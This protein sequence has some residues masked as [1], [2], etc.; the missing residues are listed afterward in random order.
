[1][2]ELREYLFSIQDIKYKI[3]TQKLVPDTSYEIIGIKVPTLKKIAKIISQNKPFCLTYLEQK[4][5]YFEEVFIHGLVLADHCK[6]ITIAKNLLNNFLPLIDNWS[7]CDCTVSALKCFN[8]EK[9]LGYEFA[10]NLLNSSSPYTIRF[11]IVLLKSYFL[12]ENFRQDS[13]NKLLEIKTDN[14]YIKM[15]IAWFLCEAL[16]KNYQ[17]TI[18]VIINKQFDKFTHNK[19]IQKCL[20]SFRISSEIKTYLKTLKI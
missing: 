14:Y 12:G 16:I 13:I 8:K 20:E 18:N 2:I 11:G 19:A 1:M 17:Q 7:I 3:F 4:H 10:I 6:N 15:A 9:N 5:K